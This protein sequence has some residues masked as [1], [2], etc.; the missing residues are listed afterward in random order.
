MALIG[1]AIIHITM[2]EESFD[3]FHSGIQYLLIQ[4]LNI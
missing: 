3:F 4:S 1:R 2:K